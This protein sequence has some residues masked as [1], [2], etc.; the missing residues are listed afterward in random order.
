[1]KTETCSFSGW[2]IYPGHGVRLVRLDSKTFLFRTSKDK[3]YFLQKQK[4]AKFRWTQVYRRL[5]KKG[6]SETRTK[7][8]KHVVKKQQRAI[9]GID[10]EKVKMMKRETPEKAKERREENLKQIRE[11]RAKA[12]ATTGKKQT[13][14]GAKSQAQAPKA[15]P[16]QRGAGKKR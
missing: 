14:G 9:Q 16:K 11:R 6:I 4:A 7:R 12:K 1:M 3:A 15:A 13:A 10:M 2:K 8:K 5:H